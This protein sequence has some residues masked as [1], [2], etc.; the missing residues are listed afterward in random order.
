MEHWLKMGLKSLSFLLI[1]SDTS[2]QA[3]K[4][5]LKVKFIPIPL[6]NIKLWCF[7]M[8][9]EGVEHGK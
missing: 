3:C 5:L 9:L 7:S 1:L 6:E 2:N 8:L 4:Y